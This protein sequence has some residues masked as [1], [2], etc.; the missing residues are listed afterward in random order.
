MPGC[1]D[2]AVDRHAILAFV[3][4]DW[5]QVAEAKAAFW[6]GRKPGRSASEILAAA[7]DLRRHAQA[8]KPGWPTE[9][10]RRA[11]LAVHERV[12]EA[13]RAASHRPR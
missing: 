13:L 7:D 2:A 3:G 12:A 9:D 1:Y 10:E 5:S 11:D 6:R 8:M 4:R